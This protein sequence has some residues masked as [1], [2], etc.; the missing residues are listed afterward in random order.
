MVR[1]QKCLRPLIW[2]ILAVDGIFLDD[3]EFFFGAN[4]RIMVVGKMEHTKVVMT[5]NIGVK[6]MIQFASIPG[7]MRK[8]FEEIFLEMGPTKT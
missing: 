4:N 3:L 2:K 8:N 1:Q 5:S 6:K 7:K